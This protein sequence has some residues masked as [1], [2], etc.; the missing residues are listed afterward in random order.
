MEIIEFCKAHIKRL[1]MVAGL[2]AVCYLCVAAAFVVV[3]LAM[4]NRRATRLQLGEAPPEMTNGENG[5]RNIPAHFLT[6]PPFSEPDEGTLFRPPMRTNFVMMGI[7]NFSL[8]DAIMVG[9]FYRDT[10]EIRLMSVP[11]DTYV[12]LSDSRHRQIMDLGLN[13][14]QQMKLNEM[15]SWGTATWGPNLI[16]Q[17]LTDMFGVPF[18]FYVEVRL[19][20][21]RRIVDNIGGVYFNVPR[22]LYYIDPCQDL[23]IDVPA[24]NRR[25]TGIQAEGLVRYRATYASGDLQRNQVQMEF[26]AAL[27]S[28]LLTREAI[29][30]NPLGLVETVITETRTNATIADALRFLPF[31]S[32][33]SADKVTTFTMPGEDG[34]RRGAGSVFIPCPEKMHEVAWEVFFANIEIPEEEEPEA[35]DEQ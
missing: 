20:A 18:H 33:A 1:F 3:A 15:R 9:T 17:E 5:E 21:F 23:V 29:M 11:R 7:D 27:F 14:P 26:M 19:T 2:V 6:P 22:R 10:G 13:I 8:A 25:L 34:Y 24:G 28:Q 35:D 16:M 12:R 4:D 31:I 30:N 32:S